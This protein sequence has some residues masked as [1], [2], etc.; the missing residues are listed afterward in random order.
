MVPDFY[1]KAI[2]AFLFICFNLYSCISVKVV[3]LLEQ[4]NPIPSWC[5]VILKTRYGNFWWVTFACR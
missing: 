1:V 5:V 4:V 2:L 3:G